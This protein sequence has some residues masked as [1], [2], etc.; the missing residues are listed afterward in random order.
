M[1]IIYLAMFFDFATHSTTNFSFLCFDTLGWL[2]S[3]LDSR[4]SFPRCRATETDRTARDGSIFA[5]P[6]R[7]PFSCVFLWHLRDSHGGI[8]S[9]YR[10][11]VPLYCLFGTVEDWSPPFLCWL[12]S[13]TG[14]FIPNAFPAMRAWSWGKN[15]G[16]KRK[17]R[18]LK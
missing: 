6:C 12:Q 8:G 10:P 5:S 11:A 17:S 7:V 15:V 13:G 4:Y 1:T 14:D 3:R 16:V 9:L 18:E 2:M